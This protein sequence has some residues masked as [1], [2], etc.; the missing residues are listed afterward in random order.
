MSEHETPIEDL[1][2]GL[3]EA[4][5]D[6]RREPGMLGITVVDWRTLADER[7]PEAWGELAGFVDW[8]TRRYQIPARKIPPCW[9]RHGALVEE[10]SALCTARLVSFD[11]LDAGYGPIGFHERLG[12]ALPRLALW[13]RGECHDGHTELPG[14]DPEPR[15]G[16]G[17]WIRQSHA[18]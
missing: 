5:D 6:G 17:D 8:L 16:W 9:W 12:A 1:L 15:S 13:Y 11:K 14:P 3:D 7:A 4:P 10:L 18:N 2:G